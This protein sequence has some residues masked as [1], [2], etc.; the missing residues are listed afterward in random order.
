VYILVE[1]FSMYGNWE[2]S[3]KLGTKQ[4]ISPQGAQPAEGFVSSLGK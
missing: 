1:I 2:K 4:E 3:K